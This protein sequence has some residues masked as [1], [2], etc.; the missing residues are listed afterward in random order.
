MYRSS[1]PNE[2]EPNLRLRFTPAKGLVYGSSAT[3]LTETGKTPEKDPVLVGEGWDRIIY[4]AKK[5]K[6]LG[7]ADPGDSP[8]QRTQVRFTPGLQMVMFGAAGAIS[9]TNATVSFE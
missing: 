7:Y 1:V 4:N 3:R 6:W 2:A 5:G 9:M 8:S